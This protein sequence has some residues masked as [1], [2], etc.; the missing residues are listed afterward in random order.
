MLDGDST[1]GGWSNAYVKAAT[2]QFTS[3]SAARP[4]DGVSLSWAPAREVDGL[5]AWFTV[6]AAHSLPATVAVSYWDGR[7]WRP[8]GGVGIQWATGSNQPTSITFDGVSTSRLRLDLT[9]GH[10]E[11]PDGFIE[12]AELSVPAS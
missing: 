1:T 12:L 4:A 10:P 7:G 3:I 8:A 2:T 5:T 11:A 6:D 9:S